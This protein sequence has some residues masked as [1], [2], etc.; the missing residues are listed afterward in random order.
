MCSGGLEGE[1][2]RDPGVL[3]PPVAVAALKSAASL[4]FCRALRA[5]TPQLPELP[6]CGVTLI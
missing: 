2:S 1:A 5:R 4:S 6:A 3:P